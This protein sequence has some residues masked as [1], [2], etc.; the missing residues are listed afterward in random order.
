MVCVLITEEDGRVRK[1]VRT[2][3]TMTADLLALSDWLD[4]LGVTHIALER[5]GVFWKPVF[6]LLEGEGRTVVLVNAQH[7]CWLKIHPGRAFAPS[8]RC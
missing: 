4:T 5:T 1:Q 6:N 8:P 2:F 7:V 3:T